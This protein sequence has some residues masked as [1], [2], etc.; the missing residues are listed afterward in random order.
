MQSGWYEN[1]GTNDTNIFTAAMSDLKPKQIT[2][3]KGIRNSSLQWTAGNKYILALSTAG[4]ETGITNIVAI[5][6]SDGSLVKL[7]EGA[8]D[9]RLVMLTLLR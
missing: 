2:S 1:V 7:L 8:G 5:S 3:F 4:N 6:T 9:K